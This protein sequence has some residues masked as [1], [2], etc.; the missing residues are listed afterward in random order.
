MFGEV[1]WMVLLAVILYFLCAVLVVLEI[2]IP[3]FGLLTVFSLTCFAGGFAIF[4]NFT[5]PWVGIV[6]AVVEI[7]VV[8]W[9]AYKFLPRTRFG[10]E[11]S[12]LPNKFE[13]G[14][15]VPDRADL[16][17][18]L[19]EK[20]K[21]LTPLRPVGTCDFDGRRVECV[22]ERGYIEKDGTVE[23]IKVDGSQV[24]VRQLDDEQ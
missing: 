13:K 3:S 11:V 2:F 5:P 1:F 20:A 7:P 23:V 15:G 19:G 18:L 8:L 9:A 6:V 12:L 4:A 16:Q 22:A 24:T 10:R 14:E 17:G 21:V